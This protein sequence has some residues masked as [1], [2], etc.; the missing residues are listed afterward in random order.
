[1]R[2]IKYLVLFLAFITLWKCSSLKQQVNSN[3]IQS[4]N[5][6][7][8]SSWNN[9][10]YW[11]VPLKNTI[12]SESLLELINKENLISGY[13]I[14]PKTDDDVFNFLTSN[15]IEDA[16][17]VSDDSKVYKFFIVKTDFEIIE[18][19]SPPDCKDSVYVNTFIIEGVRYSYPIC[20]CQINIKNIEKL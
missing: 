10:A 19:V 6:L 8:I 18:F 9:N 17:F 16:S 12:Y 14:D 15:E 11:F 13:N 5:G 4:I 1:M 2:F 3:H 7:I 20:K